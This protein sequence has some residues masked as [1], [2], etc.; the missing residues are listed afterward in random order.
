M[1]CFPNAKINIGLN[2]I[3]KRGDGFHNIETVFYPVRWC[4]A[5]EVVEK[6]VSSI[7]YQDKIKLSLS[8]LEVMGDWKAN[9]VVKAYQLLDGDFDLP[10]VKIHLYKNI[11]MG[12]GLGG[13]SADGAF[14]LKLLN[15]KFD[16]KL[17]HSKLK[18]YAQQLGSDCSFFIDNHPAFA[19]GRG[20]ELKKIDMDLSQYHIV[21]VR[22]PVHVT[23]AEAYNEVRP[24]RPV[25]SLRELIQF[26]VKEWKNYIQND[27]EE[28]V[29]KKYPVIKE[30]KEKLYLLGALYASMS[31]SGSAVYAIFDKET[32]VENAF[33]KSCVVF[34]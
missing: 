11:P 12:A 30:I 23:T 15:E 29:F 20:E 8:G 1:I 9:L 13:G 7:K 34:V 24:A 16:L 19:E 25:T 32:S 10:P 18:V 26:P 6:Q 31:G 3:E 14:A 21:I 28:S 2:I 22:P 33:D 27:F 4:D 17:N 5:L